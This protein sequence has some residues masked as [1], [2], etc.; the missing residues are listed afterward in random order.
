M[1]VWENIQF[2][3][4]LPLFF[5][6]RCSR[7]VLP[8]WWVEAHSSGLGPKVRREMGQAVGVGVVPEPVLSP[9]HR[10]FYHR[11]LLNLHFFPSESAVGFSRSGYKFLLVCF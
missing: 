1:G 5:F 8:V 7:A 9:P 11:S 4:P 3:L 6:I 10:L 2:S